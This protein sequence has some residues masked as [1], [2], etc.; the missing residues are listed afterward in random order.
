MSD[1]TYIKKRSRSA[2]PSKSHSCS[3]KPRDHN[4]YRNHDDQHRVQRNYRQQQSYN[5]P[6]NYNDSNYR[7]SLINHDSDHTKSSSYHRR[8]NSTS[9]YN[10]YRN[11][12]G[13]YQQPPSSRRSLQYNKSHRTIYSQ[14]DECNENIYRY[15][16]ACYF[17]LLFIILF[18]L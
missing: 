12:N 18:N 17:V 10:G 15:D 3:Q 9:D 6:S 7:G 4:N 2:N 14:Y 5:H 1:D 16:F 13:S 8:I 11:N